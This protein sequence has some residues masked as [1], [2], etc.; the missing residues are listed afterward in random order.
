[1]GGLVARKYMQIF[2]GKDIDRLIM[3]ATPN[4]GL[5]GDVSSYCTLFGEN[6]ECDDMEENSLF[7]NK[8]NDPSG[9]PANA[10]LYMIIG[11]GCKMDNGD[12]DGVVLVENAR[13]DN[14]ETYFVNG[15]CGNLIGN[16]LHADMLDTDKYP[17]TY[18][19]ITEILSK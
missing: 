6:R 1:M 11:Q 4:K 9:K 16:K 12:G 10:K 8:L 5:V 17:K 2:G 18:N 7:L 15:T 19:I 14:A 13:L 3:A